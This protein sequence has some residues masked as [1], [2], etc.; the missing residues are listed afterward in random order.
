MNTNKIAP[1][2][3][4]NEKVV[5]PVKKQKQEQRKAARKFLRSQISNDKLPED[6]RKAI[7]LAIGSG[8]GGGSAG[9]P[10]LDKIRELFANS[11]DGRVNV[12]DVFKATKMGIGEM[13]KRVR[14]LIR[15]V[16]P[17]DRLWIDY[18]DVKEEWV[19]QGKGEKAPAN[20]KGY[21]LPVKE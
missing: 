5:D 3:A 4:K 9:Y 8:S 11:K 20:W 10:V 19:L 17:A 16:A 2:A 6:V 14:Q 12:L 7:A 21:K 13:R 15:D 1:V 18:D